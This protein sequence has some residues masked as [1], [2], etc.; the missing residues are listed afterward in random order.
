MLINWILTYN[1]KLIF[2]DLYEQSEN[3]IITSKLEK[4][5][6]NWNDVKK[7]HLEYTAKKKGIKVNVEIDE[8]NQLTFKEENEDEKKPIGSVDVFERSS[9]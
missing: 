1:N 7:A 4:V 8:N 5:L 6:E 3:S 9:F 2:F